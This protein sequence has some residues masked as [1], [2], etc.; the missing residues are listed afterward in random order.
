MPD[1]VRKAKMLRPWK[2]RHDPPKEYVCPICKKKYGHVS[3]TR[4]W[5]SICK[6]MWGKMQERKLYD[7]IKNRKYDCCFC[8]KLQKEVIKNGLKAIDE[9]KGMV[10]GGIEDMQIRLKG[11]PK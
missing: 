10:C 6:C 4:V 3:N 11:I 9:Y 8:Q 5:V 1:V 2:E 7:Y